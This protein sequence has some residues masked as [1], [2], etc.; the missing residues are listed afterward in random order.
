M[1]AEVLSFDA[2]FRGEELAGKSKSKNQI[3]WK[4]I[5]TTGGSVLIYFVLTSVSLIAGIAYAPENTNPNNSFVAISIPMKNF[6]VQLYMFINLAESIATSKR[7]KAFQNELQQ[8]QSSQGSSVQIELFLDRLSTIVQEKKKTALITF[9]LYS[10][11][12]LPWLWPYQTVLVSV[13]VTKIFSSKL[14][15]IF[16]FMVPD[17]TTVK[18]SRISA[19]SSL[20]AISLV[21]V[22]GQQSEEIPTKTDLSSQSSNYGDQATAA[23][24]PSRLSDAPRFS[25]LDRSTRSAYWLSEHNS[26][27][28][29]ITIHDSILSAKFNVLHGNLQS[30]RDDINYMQGQFLSDASMKSNSFFD[31]A[32]IMPNNEEHDPIDAI[33]E[34]HSESASVGTSPQ[35]KIHKD[36]DKTHGLLHAKARSLR[37]FHRFEPNVPQLLRGMTDTAISGKA[38]SVPTLDDE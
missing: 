7:I 11:F 32:E 17:S 14:H 5:L 28:S 30:S 31:T 26:G 21:K 13:A 27:K 29:H 1:W 4:M 24:L 9:I 20:P 10:I 25:T 35:L 33:S 34:Q 8:T 3:R 23:A 38:S 2:L 37:F 19:F 15:F 6:G 16:Q 22:L 36:A 12:S 18:T